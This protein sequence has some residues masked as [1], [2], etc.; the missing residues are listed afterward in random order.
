MYPMRFQLCFYI[1]EDGILHSYRR[2][3]LKSYKFTIAC[4]ETLLRPAVVLKL[5]PQ[6]VCRIIHASYDKYRCVA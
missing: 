4:C 5:L 1:P 6:H 3:S 2:E